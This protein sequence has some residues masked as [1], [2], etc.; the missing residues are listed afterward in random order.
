MY[1]IQMYVSVHPRELLDYL[2]QYSLTISGN[3][4]LLHKKQDVIHY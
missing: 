3:Y 4:F 1:M 2:L